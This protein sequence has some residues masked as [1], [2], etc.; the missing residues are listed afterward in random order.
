M[1]SF[2]R[3]ES[4]FAEQLQRLLPNETE[5]KQQYVALQARG[6]EMHPEKTFIDKVKKASIFSDFIAATPAYGYL[7]RRDHD[8]TRR[9]PGFMSKVRRNGVLGPIWHMDVPA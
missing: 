9:W 5:L 3:R 8:E 1:Y 6:V 4:D 7:T 2:H